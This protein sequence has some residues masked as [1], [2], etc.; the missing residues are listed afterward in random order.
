MV[1]EKGEGGRIPIY[2]CASTAT[3]GV[4]VLLFLGH[5]P[6]NH[7]PL[8][9]NNVLLDDFWEHFMFLVQIVHA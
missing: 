3:T 9:N 6:T 1:W 7:N 2:W 8:P 5:T 4:F